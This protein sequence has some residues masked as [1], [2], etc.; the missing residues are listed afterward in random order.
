MIF[1]PYL[2]V[3]ILG[4]MLCVIGFFLMLYI[5]NYQIPAIRLQYRI[6]KINKSLKNFEAKPA[7]SVQPQSL[8]SIFSSKPF[9]HPWREFKNSLHEMENEDLSLKTIRSTLTA[10]FYF[11]KELIV[12]GFINAE[13]F[14]HL[15]GI[16]TGIGIIGTF[17]GLIWG[18]HQFNT[19][20][21]VETL[22]LLLGEVS[23]AFVGSGIAIFIAIAIT[24]F[25]KNTI[26]NCYKLIEETS[27]NLDKLY[28]AGV[29]EDYLARL[30]K[31]TETATRNSVN[32][33]DVLV[34]NLEIMMEKQSK[35][36]GM[37]IAESLTGPIDKLMLIVN[38]ASGDQSEV[39]KNLVDSL[40]NTFIAK[41]DS[42]FG[43]QIDAV[44][45]A[46]FRSTTIMESVENAMRNLI[47]DISLAGQ[48]AVKSMSEQMLETVIQANINQDE[49][50]Q[51]L[52]NVIEGIYQLNNEHHSK[53]QALIEEVMQRV[54]S[55]LSESL[56]RVAQSQEQQNL[57]DQ[58]RNHL[59]LSSAKEFQ[60]GL[61]NILQN[62]MSEHY[63]LNLK[64]KDFVQE[65]NQISS[66]HQLESN[67]R[68]Q[69][70][71]DKVLLSVDQN[72]Q[73]IL[74]E[75]EKQ[76]QDNL[77]RNIQLISNSKE[78][79]QA[80]QN[81]LK[82]SQVDQ[83]EINLKLKAFVEELNQ[84]TY[85]LQV[86]SKE[87]IEQTLEKVLG[88]VDQSVLKIS[89]L[90]E[91]LSEKDVSRNEQ[92]VLSNKEL[93]KGI[94]EQVSLSMQEQYQLNLSLKNFVSELHGMNY[95]HISQVKELML[96]S[97][98]Q[99]LAQLQASMQIIAEDRLK[100]IQSDEQR[101]IELN[102]AT[103]QLHNRISEQVKNLMLEFSNSSQ[104]SQ[105]HIQAIEKV[106]L[107]AINDMNE[108]AKT[109]DRAAQNFTNAGKDVID[110]FEQSKSITTQM[111]TIGSRLENMITNIHTLFKQ[112]EDSSS[113]H[114]DYVKELT[115]MILLAKQETGVSTKIIADMETSLKALQQSERHSLEYLQNI[116]QVL[117]DAFGQFNTQMMAQVTSLNQE[118]DRLL[119]NAI[120]SL[121][122]AV[123][124]IV[125]T[126][127]KL[128]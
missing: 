51:L 26:N 94:Q 55:S 120:N 46:I 90:H 121:T 93:H 107:I 79:Y 82:T 56:A 42:A 48:N 96:D 33:K 38:K 29:G 61:Q 37:S 125:R 5:F 19:T 117:K 114:Q 87:V 3:Y 31:A 122:S 13:F 112:F 6:K 23:S 65:V 105:D 124:Q 106:T 32:L 97:M 95:E 128:V 88:S 54:L 84:L 40:M 64:L 11:S 57:Q 4:S 20:N 66:N 62:S 39:I 91:E 115:S 47:E 113:T 14:K 127:S 28:K 98:N 74:L 101:A 76:S 35:V 83:Y 59:I 81:I 53:S 89:Q 100:Q 24:F 45:Q 110:A 119:G 15:P 108:G 50:N 102:Q 44:N 109:I 58:N 41:I 34:E 36:I 77:D 67:E 85:D 92:I 2:N 52:R 30:V 9:E 80:I 75:Q 69:Q 86:K 99:V 10:D 63:E 16:L 1:T 22:S 60:L 12:D 17:T 72:I 104:Q 71:V 111:E 8:D 123:E 70:V 18:L 126:T 43:T 68:I 103:L 27:N 49:K 116:N 7:G 118:N 25:E 78:F 21:A 73:K